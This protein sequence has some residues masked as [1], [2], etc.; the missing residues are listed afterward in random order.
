[1]LRYLSAYILRCSSKTLSRSKALRWK[2][3]SS[4]LFTVWFCRELLLLSDGGEVALDWVY[5][6]SSSVPSESRPTL[7]I[8]PGL[9]GMYRVS[10]PKLCWKTTL[11]IYVVTVLFVH[12]FSKCL[13][14][15]LLQRISGT[16]VCLGSVSVYV[17]TYGS[18]TDMSWTEKRASARVVSH[19]LYYLYYN[20]YLCI[21]RR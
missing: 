17:C 13:T 15:V 18:T 11:F 6:E 8:M 14:V 19:I 12:R 10:V 20:V 1:M 16:A 5:N 9:V 7:I 21:M 4:S 2:W 3:K